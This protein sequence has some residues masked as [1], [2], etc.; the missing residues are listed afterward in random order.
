[1]KRFLGFVK[2]EFLHI[3]R[4]YRT[5][6][7]LF[8][9]PAAQILI[10]GF[11]VSTDI[12]N[13]G[14]AFLDLSND[15]ITQKLTDK[16]VSSG[17]FKKTE[18]L[19]NYNDI[20]VIFKKGKTK[21]VVVFE[22]DFGKK[23]VSDGKASLSIIADGSE[24]N[25]ATLVTNY[26][27]AIISDFA[28]ENAGP[29]LNNSLRIN[30]EIKMFYNPNLKSHFMFVPG[31]ITMILILICALMTSVTITREKEFGTMEV[32]LVSPLRPIQIILG[33]VM[34]YFIL[35][36]INVLLILALS[37]FVFALPV[38]GSM[39][40]LLAESM[41]Y[42]LMSLTLGILISTVSSTMQQAI[43]ISLI[44][45]MLPTILL[46]GFIFPIENM[47]KIYDYVSMIMPPRYFIIIIK[48][49]MIK[50]TGLLYIWKE[51]L[52]LIAMTIVFIGLS[53]RKFKIRLE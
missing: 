20:D 29:S 15:E 4:D 44:G 28:R 24:P 27:T 10:F 39:A 26:A 23:L 50:G 34:P 19:L 9:I 46:S 30:P 32:L 7:I 48:N 6:F 11:A 53:V 47:P 1:M 43:F 33:K 49:I 31:V 12:K 51:T 52:I 22:K 16:I 3:F 17:F 25:T 41:L 5:L 8:G 38:K 42:I 13:A 40:L 45:L 36:F 18:N 14:V 21:A 37:W 2:K 35:S